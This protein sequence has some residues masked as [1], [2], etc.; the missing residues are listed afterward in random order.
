MNFGNA[1][2]TIRLLKK[3]HQKDAADLLHMD[4]RNLRRIESNKT[5]ITAEQLVQFAEVYRVDITYIFQ[6][7]QG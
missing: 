3:I 2:K 1:L 6:L 4:V 7:A 5:R